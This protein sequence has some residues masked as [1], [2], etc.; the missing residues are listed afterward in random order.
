M[1]YQKD[2]KGVGIFGSHA[3]DLIGFSKPGALH[4]VSPA[5]IGALRAPVL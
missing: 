3:G 5:T 1:V 2:Q 4:P